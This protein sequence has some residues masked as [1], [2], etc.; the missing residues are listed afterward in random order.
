MILY[1]MISVTVRLWK[2]KFDIL[3][4]KFHFSCQILRIHRPLKS[5]YVVDIRSKANTTRG[6]NFDHMIKQEHTREG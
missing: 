6:L 2:I 5:A 3:S 4:E 1:F